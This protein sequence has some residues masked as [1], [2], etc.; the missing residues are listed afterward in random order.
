VRSLYGSLRL[1]GAVEA[2]YCI[3]ELILTVGAEHGYNLSL[4]PVDLEPNTL[5]SQHG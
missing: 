3:E 1:Y 2:R 4:T 5:H